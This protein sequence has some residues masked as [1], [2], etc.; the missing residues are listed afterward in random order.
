MFLLAFVQKTQKKLPGD[1]QFQMLL[2]KMNNKEELYLNIPMPAYY[3]YLI[4]KEH[5][6]RI[7]L[8][9]VWQQTTQRCPQSTHSW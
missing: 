8:I 2:S 6:G 5:R 1:E 7:K 4:T 3:R 9:L